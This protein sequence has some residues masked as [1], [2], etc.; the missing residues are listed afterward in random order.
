MFQEDGLWCMVMDY[1]EARDLNSYLKQQGKLAEPEAIAII[2]KIGE[3]LYYVHQQNILHRDIKPHNILLRRSDLSPIIIDFGLARELMPELTMQRMTSNETRFYMPVEQ[4]QENGNCGAWTDIYAL[5]A[6]L[7]VLVV[8]EENTPDHDSRVRQIEYEL[9][10]PDPLP[11]PN[12]HS[13]NLSDKT[14]QAILK[15]MAIEPE[16][17]PQ[18]VLEWLKLLPQPIITLQLGQTLTKRPYHI[19]RELGQGGFGITYKAKHLNLHFHTVI[20]TP[21]ARL[22]QDP[23]Y[24]EYV[25]Q[26]KK[27]GRLLAQ[28]LQNPHPHIVRISDLFEENGLPCIVMDFIPGQSLLAIVK[29][30]GKLAEAK[31]IEY[32]QQIGSALILCHNA[33]IIHRD[34]HPNNILIHADNGKAVLIDFGIAGNVTNSSVNKAGNEAFAPWEQMIQGE[35]AATVDIYTLAAT[36]YYLVTRKVPIP[37]V[38]RKLSRTDGLE[39]PKQLNP[40]LSDRINEAILKGMELEPEN[41]PQTMQEWLEMLKPKRSPQPP[42]PRPS[43]PPLQSYRVYT[44]QNEL[45]FRM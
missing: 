41:R 3:A 38:S 26:F 4:Y 39:A 43:A 7:Y 37:C 16:N 32:I 10:N 44:S 33:G 9:Q 25:E 19:E 15:G 45:S 12:Q 8:G 27:E 20:K 30:Q 2:T 35:K 21:N 24:E 28:F 36:L 42:I 23:N 1:I 6:T 29:N 31:A 34:C 14:N 18:T 40:D 22:Q 17:R 5:A 11:P 13:P